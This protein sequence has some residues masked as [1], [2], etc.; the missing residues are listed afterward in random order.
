M[1]RFLSKLILPK[2]LL[3]ILLLLMIPVLTAQMNRSHD[4]PVH[5]DPA[6]AASA[7]TQKKPTTLLVT[8]YDCAGHHTDTI[9]LASLDTEHDRL[10]VLRIPRDCYLSHPD[11]PAGKINSVYS[12]AYN[13]AITDK[14]S[15]T[16]ARAAGNQALCR[17]I[18]QVFGVQVDGYFSM[19]TDGF[20][21]IVDSVGGVEV[22]I[23]KEMDYDDNSQNL[24]IHLPKG[25][26]HLDGNKAE[27]FVRFRSGYQNG[28]YGR[29]DA[30]NLLLAA[31]F[32]K[33]Q[34]DFT[35]STALSLITTAF[36]EVDSN[37]SLGELLPI[38]RTALG[39]NFSEVKIA[40]MK[41]E[42]RMI[43][44]RMCEVMDRRVARDL[45]NYYLAAGK[46]ESDFDPLHA[47][48]PPKTN[49]S[50]ENGA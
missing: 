12:T 20:R 3:P 47:L 26:V 46:S 49:I 30:Q 15:E 34:T 44:G 35:L 43:D 18:D 33:L 36:R 37:L 6:T 38:A 23:P 32:K 11:C 27:Q 25:K 10:R 21:K 5:A 42:G 19:G 22:N 1:N 28:D 9:L 50:K 2:L 29:M 14:K 13:K 24:H 41:G 8:G 31:L 7:S 4:T 17:V 39:L 48:E 45:M 16:A 40:V